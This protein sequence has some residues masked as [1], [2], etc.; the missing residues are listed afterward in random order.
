MSPEQRLKEIEDRLLKLD[1]ER[2][3]LLREI[4]NIRNDIALESKSKRTLLGRP[5][6]RKELLTN[7]DKV[8][9][10]LQMFA[11]RLDVYPIISQ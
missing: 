3:L 10:F 1:N 5:L 4:Q 6:N 2:I 7:A 9:L 8:Q 11:A